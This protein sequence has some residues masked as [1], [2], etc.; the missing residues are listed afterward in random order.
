MA[1]C[2]TCKYSVQSTQIMYFYCM[3]NE[4]N[5]NTDREDRCKRTQ[6][7]DCPYYTRKPQKGGAE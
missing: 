6:G 3:N 1:E 7:I 2:K 5:K 4:R